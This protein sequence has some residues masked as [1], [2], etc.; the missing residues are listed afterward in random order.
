MV[1]LRVYEFISKNYLLN[2]YNEN[3]L[4]NFIL[5]YLIELNHD[6]FPARH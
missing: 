3:I 1:F 6:L 2:N 5:F 4:H